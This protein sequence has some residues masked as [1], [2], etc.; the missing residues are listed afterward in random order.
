M[1]IFTVLIGFGIWLSFRQI[2]GDK[3]PYKHKFEGPI[4]STIGLLLSVMVGMLS[5]GETTENFKALY[6]L[7]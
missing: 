6:G 1:W 7:N 2:K 5:G 4:L 3:Q